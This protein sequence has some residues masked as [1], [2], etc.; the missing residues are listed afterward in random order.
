MKNTFFGFLVLFLSLTKSLTAGDSQG[1]LDYKA[2]VEILKSAKD[3]AQQ[4]AALEKFQSAAEEGYPDAFG[5]IG[6]FHANGI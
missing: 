4:A 1:E 6:Y 2:G 5:A 3:L